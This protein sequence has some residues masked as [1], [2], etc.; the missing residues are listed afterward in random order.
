MKTIAN[1]LFLAFAGFAVMLSPGFSDRLRA[2]GAPQKTA[3]TGY[4]DFSIVPPNLGPYTLPGTD[5]DLYVRH[6]PLVGKFTLA[7]KGITLDAKINVDFNAE[8]D[9]TGTGVAWFPVT[10]TATVNG[11]KTIIFDGQGSANEVLLV[12][13]GNVSLKGC[14]PYRGMKLE[15]SFEEIGPGDSNTY[16]YR[17]CLMPASVQ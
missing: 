1:K 4:I 7:G 2:D 8:F 6:L 5:G 12:S 3:V 14:G 11:V 10:I 13:T 17:G 16:N 15:F 9:V